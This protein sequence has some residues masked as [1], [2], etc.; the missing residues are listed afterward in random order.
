ALGSAALGCWL[1]GRRPQ[2]GWLAGGALLG[3]LL[4]ALNPYGT[5]IWMF[6]FSLLGRDAFRLGLNEWAAPDLLGAQLGYLVLAL[7]AAAL[8]LVRGREDRVLCLWALL[9]LAAGLKTWRH[10][11]LAALAL[12]YIL[13]GL[14][15][16]LRWPS[17][18]MVGPIL[19]LVAGLVLWQRASGGVERLTGLH[20]FFPVYACDWIEANP[21][22]PERIL[23][24]YEWGGYLLWRLGPQRKV[25][26]DGRAHTVYPEQV[27]IDGLFTQFGEPWSRL[28]AR[29]G[30]APPSGDLA[31]ILE[32][33]QVEMVLCNR[34]QGNLAQRMPAGWYLAY[35]DGNCQA[36]LRD[37]P[38]NRGRTLLVPPR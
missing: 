7:S 1:E 31:E 4:T 27:Y 16:E 8:V 18:W 30:F 11:P 6:P 33:Y 37:T 5:S 3:Y 21:G 26:F 9:F 23:N 24:P 14:L 32:R 10:E 35:E 2:A 15:P 25:F 13:P 28:L 12:A 36:F 19:S 29:E 17:R 38:E 20:T 22:L 34:L